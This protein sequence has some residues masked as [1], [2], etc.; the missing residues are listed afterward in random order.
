[1]DV[2]W[3]HLSDMSSLATGESRFPLLSTVARLV[4]VIPHSNAGEERVFSLINKNKTSSRPSLALHGT[5]S[6]I[7]QVKMATP[8][9]CP[10]FEPP[11]EV[12]TKAEK[13][14]WEYS[15]RHSSKP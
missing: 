7:I 14:T 4:L 12:P 2:L 13:A 8:D 9:H 15:K 10:T 5:L 1:M 11:K 3:A 6:L